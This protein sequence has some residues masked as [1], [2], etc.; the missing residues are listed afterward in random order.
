MEFIS[1]SYQGSYFLRQA[2]VTINLSLKDL[3][4]V[5]P[6]DISYLKDVLSIPPQRRPEDGDPA[7]HRGV[8][9]P[10]CS[11]GTEVDLRLCFGKVSRVLLDLV[12]K[13]HTV[14]EDKKV[15]HPDK[16]PGFRIS[17]PLPPLLCMSQA[18]SW[19]TAVL[20]LEEPAPS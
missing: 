14:Q 17:F 15:K 11:R 1:T 6:V 7:A 8:A 10:H 9:R 19:S 16:D 12:H 2:E 3:V 20:V 18:L 4:C 5:T 13:T